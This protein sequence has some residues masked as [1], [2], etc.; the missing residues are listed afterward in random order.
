MPLIEYEPG[1]TFPGVIGRTAEESIPAWPAPPR[2]RKGAPNVLFIVLDDTGF[3]QLG[4]YGSP[5]ATPNLDGIAANGL[6]YNNM[7]T[8]ALCSPS[9]SCIVTGRNHHANGMACITELATGFPGYDG[10]MPFENGMLSE[11][12]V[13]QG[14]STF[15]VGKWH[16]TPSNHETAAGPYD[17][18]PLG[19]GFQRFYGFLGGD[20]S[21]WYPDLVYDNHQVEPPRTPEEGYHLSE[22]L[23]DKA[24][25]FIADSKQADPDKPFYLHLCFGATHAPHHVAKEWADRYTGVFDDGWDAYREK[26]FARQKEL[27]IVPADAE[28]SRHDPDVP[29]WDSLPAPARRLYGRMMEVFAG[30]L[31]HTD[32]QIGRLLDFLAQQGELEDT[33]IMVIS[34]NGASA[35]GGPTGTTNEAQF[36]NNAQE[37]IEESLKSIDEIGGPKH[38]NHYP[39]GWT[40][41]GNTPF[42]RWKRETYRGGSSDPFIVSWPKKIKPRGEVRNQYGHIIDMVPTVLDL[43][44]L[45]PPAEIRGVSQSPLHG[46]SFAHTFDDPDAASKRPTQ[47]F[48]ML[49]HRSIYHDG[50][51][52]VCP[53]PGPSFAEAGMPFGQPISSETLSTLDAT[54]WELYHVED[55]FAEARNVAA[56]NRDRLIAMIGTWYVEAGK[57]DVMPIDGS[58]LARMVGEKPLIALPRDSYTYMPNTQSVPNFAAPKVLNRPHSITADVEIPDQGAE[59]VLLSQGTAAGG[60]SFFMKDG[61]LR[62]VHNYV[63][64][65]LLSVES[66]EEVPPGKHELRFEFEPTGMPDMPHGKGAPGRLQLYIDGELAGD[67]DADVTTPFMFNPGALT[68]GANPGS[69]VTPEYK[70]PFTFTGTLHSV[71]LDVSGELIQDPEAELRVHL[72]RQ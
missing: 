67:A 29:D 22:D 71:T 50:W 63:G 33:L 72:A 25:S 68:C 66:D 28:L 70:G 51:R 60:Y 46:V 45:Q 57:Y 19:R 49:G 55:D 43:L 32:H 54:G 7:H 10:V 20:T 24:V 13:E 12:L 69:P 41:A 11:V 9:R 6:R 27:G 39:W 31:S 2:A 37:P 21:Q 4:C 34:D 36:F 3:G 52:A 8:T 14:Y 18:W 40:W 1:A 47:Y 5:I 64:R 30:F 23:V 53:W 44:G 17:R 61:K 58:G 56:E 38:F 65:R 15:M 48:E 62:Y 35:E 16:L 59:G 26:T 42:R